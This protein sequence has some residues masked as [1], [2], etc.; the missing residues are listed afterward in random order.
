[1]MS[2][3]GIYLLIGISVIHLWLGVITGVIGL[4]ILRRKRLILQD[5][6]Y[7]QQHAPLYQPFTPALTMTELKR[8]TQQT[9]LVTKPLGAVKHTTHSEQIAIEILPDHEQ[10]TLHH[11]ENNVERL[12]K[13]LTKAR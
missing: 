10:P 11:P 9:R 5:R 6:V 3:N 12:V 13:Q 8:E 7:L 2:E 4:S 1:M